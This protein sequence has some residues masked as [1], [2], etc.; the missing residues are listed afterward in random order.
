MDDGAGLGVP[1]GDPAALA[2]V[3]VRL[4]TNDSLHR[5]LARASM[6]AAAGHTREQQAGETIESL[7]TGALEINYQRHGLAI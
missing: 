4:K 3:A 6:A 7:S 2:E 5:N 1:A